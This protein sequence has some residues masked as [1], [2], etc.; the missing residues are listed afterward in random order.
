[1]AP[2]VLD[3]GP[4]PARESRNRSERQSQDR[5]RG[6]SLPNRQRTDQIRPIRTWRNPP[7]A[8]DRPRAELGVDPHD[9]EERLSLSTRTRYAH[10]SSSPTSRVD[11]LDDDGDGPAGAS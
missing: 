1:M 2:G 9:L 6:E 10:G 5:L 3:V 4:E 7:R 8:A 11:A